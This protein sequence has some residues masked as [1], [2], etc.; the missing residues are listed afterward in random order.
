[1]I[2]PKQE[3]KQFSSELLSSQR[4]PLVEALS[5][6]RH[7]ILGQAVELGY[8]IRSDLRAYRHSGTTNTCHEKAALLQQTLPEEHWSPNRVIKA[9]YGVVGSEPYVFVLPEL[10]MEGHAPKKKPHNGGSL[11][12][13]RTLNRWGKSFGIVNES[14]VEKLFT[15][16]GLQSQDYRPFFAPRVPRMRSDN[17][18]IEVIP[19]GYE[20]VYDKN[21]CIPSSM[22]SGTCTPFVSFAE[23]YSNPL[24]RGKINDNYGGI[25]AV[26]I[27]DEPSLDDK[28]VDI[29]VGGRGAEAHKTSLHLP[30]KA[31]YEILVETYGK[32]KVFRMAF[33]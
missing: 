15:E 14:V 24:E 27:H 16:A 26:F 17:S 3:P 23:I 25:R 31:I 21:E 29:S 12:K 18:V 2:L 10:R 1:M 32:K 28:L 7:Y 11:R 22:E 4:I 19:E 30:Y 20:A 33:W 9:L 6:E 5:R 8:D 13:R